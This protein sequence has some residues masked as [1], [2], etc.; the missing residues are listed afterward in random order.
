MPADIHASLR[1]TALSLAV[2]TTALGASAM[3]ASTLHYASHIPNMVLAWLGASIVTAGLV[4]V[5]LANDNEGTATAT[6]HG[7]ND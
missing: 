1:R 5:S 7:F 6:P 4:A 3:L 2:F